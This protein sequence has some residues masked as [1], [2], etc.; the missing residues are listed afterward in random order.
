[1]DLKTLL[2]TPIYFSVLK[3]KRSGTK[4]RN[5][6][7]WNGTLS[8]IVEETE[9]HGGLLVLNLQPESRVTHFTFSKSFPLKFQDINISPAGNK[10]RSN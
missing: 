6:K 8:E 10:L 1:V 2:R 5:L 4:S 7:Q 9:G 3:G